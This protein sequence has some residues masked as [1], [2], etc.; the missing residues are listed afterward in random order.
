[1]SMGRVQVGKCYV[2]KLRF[3]GFLFA[4]ARGNLCYRDFAQ[5]LFYKDLRTVDLCHLTKG[6]FFGII[7][8][9][10]SL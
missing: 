3:G 5:L 9:K 2:E 7:K 1:M 8:Q 10:N 4:F 6:R